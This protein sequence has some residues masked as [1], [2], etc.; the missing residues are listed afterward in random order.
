MAMVVAVG[1]KPEEDNN[2]GDNNGGQNDSIVDHSGTL[3][4]HDFIDLG[5]LIRPICSAPQN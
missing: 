5:R 4:G 3:N 2:G 1:C